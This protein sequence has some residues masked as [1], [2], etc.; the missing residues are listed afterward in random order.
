MVA[1]GLHCLPA[2][3][4]MKLNNNVKSA[5]YTNS[6]I[7]EISTAYAYILWPGVW[8]WIKL[9]VLLSYLKYRR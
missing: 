7:P 2:L 1:V 5:F 6:E 8:R 4:H 3:N 9:N